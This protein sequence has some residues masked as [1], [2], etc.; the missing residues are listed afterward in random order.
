MLYQFKGRLCGL[1][2]AE[3]PEALSDVY[4]R[5][6]RHHSAQDIT[7]LAVAHP[8]DTFAI[9]LDQETVID[10]AGRP[11]LFANARKSSQNRAFTSEWSIAS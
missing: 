10:F 9:L 4:V 2:C 11:F 1:V 5:L 6:Y 3:C 8:K 7:A